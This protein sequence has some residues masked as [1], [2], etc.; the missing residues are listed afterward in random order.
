MPKLGVLHRCPHYL[1]FLNVLRAK[2]APY[3]WSAKVSRPTCSH[4]SHRRVNQYFEVTLWFGV[5]ADVESNASIQSSNKIF[6]QQCHIS[7]K[8]IALPENKELTS[9][10]ASFAANFSG[11]RPSLFL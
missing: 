2:Q 1:N 8:E 11:V 7:V 5:N 10:L 4:D 9:A 3:E 6:N